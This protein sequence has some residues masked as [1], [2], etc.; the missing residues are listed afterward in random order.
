MTKWILT[1]L[2]LFTLIRLSAQQ[3]PLFTQY[4]FN[5]M[6]FNPA[7]AGSGGAFTTDLIARFQWTGMEGAPRTLSF[8]A[9][10]PLRNPHLGLGLFVYRDELG[11]TVDY[12]AMGAFAYRI[13]FPNSTLCFGIQA[14]IKKMDVDRGMLDAKD[15]GDPEIVSHVTNRVV[16]DVDFGIYYY[17]RYYYYSGFSVKHLL[18][19]Q[20]LTTST[21]PDGESG[22][23]RLMRSWYAMA[24]GVIPLGDNLV[25]LPSALGK[26][27][28]GAPFQADLNLSIRFMKLVT[29]GITY[30][31]RSA[32]GLMV[33]ITIAKG[34]SIGYSYDIWFNSLK[35]YN[36]GSHE[37]RIGYDIDLFDRE[38]ILTP[39]FF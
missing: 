13:L 20:M 32:L 16:P 27:V 4:M 15:P 18:Q 10:T 5:K 25:L 19:N 34:I 29:A 14:G 6:A 9:Q 35:S 21:T 33:G 31:T 3:D 24:G 39:R 36:S 22:F 38:R 30:R 26:Y 28:Y 17:G 1:G 8:S 23:T 11:P 37:I 2:L 12:G 7:Y